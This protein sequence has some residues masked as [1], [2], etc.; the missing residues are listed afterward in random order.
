MKL[1]DRL[2]PPMALMVRQVRGWLD[3]AEAFAAQ[4]K[5][6]PEVLLSARLAPDQWHL[7]R[8]IQMVAWFPTQLRTMLAGEE[9]KQFTL[10]EE[11]L[12]DLRASL[13]RA[14]VALEAL[15]PE[16]LD[17]AADRTFA[18]PATPGKGMLGTDLV[19]QMI[20]PNFYFHAAMTYAILRHNGVE[21]GKMDFLGPIDIRDL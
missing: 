16:L 5:I 10:V 18:M 13:D 11:P 12:G 2:V 9:L 1:H 20:L 15:T 6:D 21:L 3:K 14:L 17:S 8:Q 19:G 4:K 7:R